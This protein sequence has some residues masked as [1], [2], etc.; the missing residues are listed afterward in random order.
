MR[1]VIITEGSCV[2]VCVLPF[3]LFLSLSL[4]IY[5][6]VPFSSDW[7]LIFPFI[8]L[9]LLTSSLISLSIYLSVSC[10][11]LLL[12][13]HLSF[14]RFFIDLSLPTYLSIFPYLLQVYHHFNSLSLS[15]YLSIYLITHSEAQVGKCWLPWRPFRHLERKGK[16]RCVHNSKVKF[17]CVFW[18]GVSSNWGVGT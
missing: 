4:F 7:M 9:S 1:D 17:R 3:F 11:R 13:Y 5:L 2:Y 16:S 18:T 10:S 8:Y 12:V 14:Y 15:T 6:S